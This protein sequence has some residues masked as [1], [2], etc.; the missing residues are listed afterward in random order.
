MH[1]TELYTYSYISSYIILT[2]QPLITS[3]SSDG[4]FPS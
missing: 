3:S 4:I 2:E 1:G